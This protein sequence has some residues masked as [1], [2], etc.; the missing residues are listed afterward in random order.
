MT[1]PPMWRHFLGWVSPKEEFLVWPLEAEEAQL[2]KKYFIAF[3]ILRH[4]H[5]FALHN[6]VLAKH[7]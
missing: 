3:N 1:W 6:H 5:H 2:D 4:I 7:S